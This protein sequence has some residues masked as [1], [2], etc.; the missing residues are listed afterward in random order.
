MKLL[1]GESKRKNGT[2]QYRYTYLGKRYSIYAKTLKELREKERK[3][4][5]ESSDKGL[6]TVDDMVA[7]WFRTK[8]NLRPSTMR[9]YNLSIKKIA[10]RFN[11]VKMRTLK[12]SDIKEWFIDLEDEGYSASF[13]KTTKC[14]LQSACQYAIEDELL[15]KNIF[16][17][18]LNFLILRTQ[19]RRALTDFE[20]R[21]LLDYAFEKDKYLYYISVFLL[22]T[23][24]RIGEFCGLT[25]YDFDYV[26]N[27]IDVNKQ[28][29][30]INS[31]KYMG[32][33]KT[34]S[35][36]R[37]IPLTT[38]AKECVEYFRAHS[39]GIN[40]VSKSPQ[41]L[42]LNFLKA[43]KALG[44]KVSPHVLRH[45]FCTNLSNKG[46]N[47]KSLQYLMGHST[48]TTTLNVYADMTAQEAQRQMLKVL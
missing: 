5:Y 13:I 15:D 43:Q 11:G 27:F 4:D 3:I 32:D 2:F 25:F 40:I 8:R 42:R 12:I 37:K 23:G 36:Y 9:S 47:L 34:K 14:I 48:L 26:N 17:F 22:E 35:S 30:C 41:Q 46:I 10:Q 44:I 1:K 28:L 29:V 16:T 38:K 19:P 31:T 18:K 21:K 6:I 24:V 7:R 45:T 33:L 20:V 39:N